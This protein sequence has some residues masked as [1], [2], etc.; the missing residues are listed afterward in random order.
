MALNWNFDE[1]YQVA[2]P[3]LQ[4][5]ENWWSAFFSPSFAGAILG[6]VVGGGIS[7]GVTRWATNKQLDRDEETRKQRDKA[8]AISALIRYQKIVH[9]FRTIKKRISEEGDEGL[10]LRGIDEHFWP[11]LKIISNLDLEIGQPTP[12]E[13]SVL[14]KSGEKE[15]SKSI[16]RI[17]RKTNS[18]INYCSEYNI[19][20]KELMNSSKIAVE[21]GESTMRFDEEFFRKEIQKFLT[22]SILE[23][24]IRKLS[25]D[26]KGETEETNKYLMSV[27]TDYFKDDA[28]SIDY[29]TSSASV[30]G[31]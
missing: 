18:L 15:L 11:K 20:K 21:D 1:C 2:S 5:A 17:C 31:D 24:R 10:A 25:D 23:E 4:A 7:A 9:A 13:I 26:D 22:L 27:L 19:L 30:E 28:F 8:L 12:E 16:I 3:L 14:L 29:T 6:A